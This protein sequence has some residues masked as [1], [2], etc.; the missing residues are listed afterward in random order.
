MEMDADEISSAE[1]AD[2]F[3]QT[4]QKRWYSSI[5]TYPHCSV[6]VHSN[7]MFRITDSRHSCRDQAFL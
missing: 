3:E 7:I 5:F 4:W 6:G 2:V 1:L